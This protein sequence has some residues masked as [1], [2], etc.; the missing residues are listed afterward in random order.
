MPDIKRKTL[1]TA[2][3]RTLTIAV[4]VV[5]QFVLTPII[6][7]FLGTTLYGIYTIVNK[8]NNFLSIVDIRPTAILRLKLAHEQL[9]GNSI[10][11]RRY[12]GASYVISMLFTP[13]FVIGGCILACYF[14]DLF[15]IETKF[16]GETRYAIISLSVFLAIN[17]FW[18]IPEASLRGSNLEYKG[19]F[20]EPI[21]LLLVAA[22]TILFLYLRMGLMSVIYAMFIGSLFAYISRTM[23]RRRFLPDLYAIAPT[24]AHVKYFFNKGGWYMLSSFI[25]QVINNFDVILIGILMTPEAVTIFAVTKSIIFRISESAETLITSTTSSIGEIVGSGNK[26]RMNNAR[27]SLFNLAIPLSL[28]IA[29]YFFLFNEAFIAFWTGSDVY[30]GNTINTLIC[31][32]AIFLMLTSTEEIFV[33]SSLNFTV[34]TCCLFI[35]ATIAILISIILNDKLGLVGNAIGIL[36]GRITLFVLYFLY[37]NKL[38]GDNLHF[39]VSYIMKIICLTVIVAMFKVFMSDFI[40]STLF[41][42][43][44]GSFGFIVIVGSYIYFL[45]LEKKIKIQLSSL[46]LRK[47]DTLK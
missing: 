5:S 36:T 11:K 24:F 8:A 38:I 12:I 47:I 14:P 20:I 4:N 43:I 30:A 42:F 21:R 22:L 32:S 31:I 37:N 35:S 10:E 40:A 19:F 23:L 46:L 34:K 3:S 15:H 25:M 9:S 6:L 41:N 1:Y 33:Q 44:I 26:V 13:I 16:V 39:K 2:F 27:T 28:F 17:G 29:S 18:G 7:N 45:L